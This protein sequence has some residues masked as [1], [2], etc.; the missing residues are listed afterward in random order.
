MLISSISIYFDFDEAP[1]LLVA[2]DVL[3]L[4]A[5]LFADGAV[6]PRV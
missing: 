4:P 5:I 1:V 2:L 3:L 6:P